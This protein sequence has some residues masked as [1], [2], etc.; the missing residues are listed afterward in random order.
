MKRLIITEILAM[1]TMLFMITLTDCSGPGSTGNTNTNTNVVTI[2]YSLSNISGVW[3]AFSIITNSGITMTI[4]DPIIS[5]MMEKMYTNKLSVVNNGSYSA[6]QYRDLYII[7]DGIV[8]LSSSSSANIWNLSGTNAEV[9]MNTYTMRNGLHTIQ[10]WLKVYDGGN[11]YVIGDVIYIF[12]SNS[13]VD[14]TNIADPVDDWHGLQG[15]LYFPINGGADGTYIPG[16]SDITNV[17]ISVA[18]GNIKIKMSMSNLSTAWSPAYGYDHVSFQVFLDNPN[19]TGV[20]FMPRQYGSVPAPMTEWDYEIMADGW[21]PAL[22][23]SDG[24]ESGKFGSS[25]G[26]PQIN[27]NADAST[28]EF[29][30][31]S[32]MIGYPN[33]LV[34]WDIYITTFD[35]DGTAS[36][37]R[38]VDLTNSIADHQIHSDRADL[39]DSEG[40]YTNTRIMDWV[41]PI[42]INY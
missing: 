35:Y 26:T 41:G 37:F 11:K 10:P 18:G 27:V 8:D 29:I 2:D 5:N 22:Y 16:L 21:T 33:S 25:V 4:L 9:V 28:V 40:N 13:F 31:F 20:S 36:D 42:T 3:G 32:D 24:A 6:S 12:V 7:A 14:V 1:L 38:P 30:L 34:G 23:S 17:Y 15:D 39:F 19:E